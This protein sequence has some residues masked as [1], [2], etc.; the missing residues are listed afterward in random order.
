MLRELKCSLCKNE[1]S[2][3]VLGIGEPAIE[4]CGMFNLKDPP[5]RTNADRIRGMTDE[6]LAEWTAKRV[7]CIR[8]PIALDVCQSVYE[9]NNGECVKILL[10][11]LQSPVEADT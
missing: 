4:K 6:E 5:A 7:A 3:A 8:C 11:W 2:C 10:G 1:K 9:K